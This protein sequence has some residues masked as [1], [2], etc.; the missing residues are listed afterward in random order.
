MC[1]GNTSLLTH[2]SLV[3]GHLS[4]Q[5]NDGTLRAT[6]L[7][8]TPESSARMTSKDAGRQSQEPESRGPGVNLSRSL[9]L[10]DQRQSPFWWN[11]AGLG[12]GRF[13][14]AADATVKSP[15]VS[16]LLQSS[17]RL[18]TLP[19]PLSALRMHL[20]FG[21]GPRN[22]GARLWAGP[23]FPFALCPLASCLTFFQRLLLCLFFLVAFPSWDFSCFFLLVCGTSPLPRALSSWPSGGRQGPEAG[24]FTVGR[25]LMLLWEWPEGLSSWKRKWSLRHWCS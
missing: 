2:R 11:S 13:A 16:L 20:L 25:D 18:P 6:R 23:W 24:V 3:L 4:V 10:Q 9:G 19:R 15:R 8:L 17:S 1:I 22:A 7:P 21:S 14:G 12:R 5:W